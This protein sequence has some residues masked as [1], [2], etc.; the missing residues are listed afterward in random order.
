VT[1]EKV[2]DVLLNKTQCYLK[3]L[4]LVIPN[5]DPNLLAD[6]IIPILF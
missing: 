2:D 6:Q 4:E 5:A 1:A 3:L